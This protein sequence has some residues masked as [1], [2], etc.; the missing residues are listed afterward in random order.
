MEEPEVIA[1]CEMSVDG[2]DMR[3]R[4]PKPFSSSWYSHKFKGPG[5]RYEVFVAVHSGM[6]IWL[7]GPFACGAFPDQKIFNL[8]LVH[9]LN[10]NEKV[11]ADQ[12]YSGESVLTKSLLSNSRNELHKR[13]RARHENLNRRLNTYRVLSDVFR[14]AIDLHQ[15]CTFAVSNIV[16]LSLEFDSGLLEL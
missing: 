11:I 2:V 7:H 3:I 5:V 8:A 9:H 16:Q 13:K 6:I 1:C 14:H 15:V 12:G 10:Q 4:E